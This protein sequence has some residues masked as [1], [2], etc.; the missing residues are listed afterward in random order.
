MGARLTPPSGDD[1]RGNKDDSSGR[2]GSRGRG[3]GL[4]RGLS[5]GRRSRGGGRSVK[6]HAAPQR[7]SE[8]L[9]LKERERG[10]GKPNANSISLVEAWKKAYPGLGSD[11]S[12]TGD[13]AWNSAT[14]YSGVEVYEEIREH[15]LA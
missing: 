3:R 5:C 15:T 4:G 12:C 14:W 11:I 9:K 1:D 8:R 6:G 7:S 2:G 10:K 13:P